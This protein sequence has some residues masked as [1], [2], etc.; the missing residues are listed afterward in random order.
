V[1]TE[2]VGALRVLRRADCCASL[3]SRQQS[4]VVRAEGVF[5]Q[6]VEFQ[7]TPC[8]PCGLEALL[9]ERRFRLRDRFFVLGRRFGRHSDRQLVEAAFGR[10]Q[11]AGAAL[12]IS[13]CDCHLAEKS[14]HAD[15]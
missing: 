6:L 10:G 9:R 8:A 14:E 15:G 13:G 12:G 1:L 5:D 11:E 3:R 4:G 7:F 2:V